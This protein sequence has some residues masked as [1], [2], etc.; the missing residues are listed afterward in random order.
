[1]LPY[2]HL[3]SLALGPLKIQVW[4]LFVAA[5]FLIGL[6]IART[7]AKQAGV[8]VETVENLILW[9][10][11]F[12]LFFSRVFYVLFGGEF[13]VF[14]QKPW[15]ILAIWQGGMMSTGGFF[16]VIVVL[17]YKKYSFLCHSDP[18]SANRLSGEESL[19]PY[20]D[21][22]AYAFPFGWLIGRIGC[23]FTHLHPGRLTNSN[24]GVNFIEGAR[25]DMAILE[26]L[27][28][29]P[30]AILFIIFSKKQHA[31][32]FYTVW[33]LLWYGVS[34][35]FLDFF[36]ATDLPLS[37]ARYFNLTVAQWGGILLILIGLAMSLRAKRSNLVISK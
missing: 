12:S 28:L 37:D 15:L 7:R 32:G 27:A 2:F 1:M 3:S 33:L 31:A 35:F 36:R 26:V 18:P 17:I 6:L 14:L 22:L 11:I 19:W 21:I 4:G 29:L 23:F 16:G 13:G 30:L 9:I 25:L 8:K 5:G 20:L 10:V 24:L 34:R